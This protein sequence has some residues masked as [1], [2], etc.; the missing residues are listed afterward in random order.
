MAL[1]N[2]KRQTGNVE[3]T[4]SFNLE[5]FKHRNVKFNVWDLGGQERVRPMWKQYFTGTQGLVFVVDSAD[6]GRISEAERELSRIISDPEMKDVSVLIFANK[7]DLQG[8]M[9]PEAVENKLTCLRGRHF[10]LQASCAVTGEGVREGFTWL[11]SQ[12]QPA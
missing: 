9:G 1:A 5:N 11:A 10:H 3:H 6:H 8:A 12:H 4:E 7:E 2:Q